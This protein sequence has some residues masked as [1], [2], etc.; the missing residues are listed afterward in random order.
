MLVYCCGWVVVLLAES[1]VIY[2]SAGGSPFYS[3]ADFYEIKLCID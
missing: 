2:V 3:V 1:F